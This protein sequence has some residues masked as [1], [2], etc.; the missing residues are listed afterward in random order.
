MVS[1]MQQNDQNTAVEIKSL[2]Q[3]S[4]DLIQHILLKNIV[5]FW[6]PQTLDME[7]GGFQ[8]NHDQQGRFKGPGKKMIVT[9]ARAVWF[10]SNL[11]NNGYTDNQYIKAAK[12]G[13]EFLREAMWDKEHGGFYWEVDTTGHT[14]TRPMKHLYGQGFGLYALSEYAMALNSKT[15]LE[16]A[17]K[18]FY[19]LERKAHDKT[20]GGYVESFNRDWSLPPGDENSYMSVPHKYKLMNTHLHLL[21]P[22][23]VYYQAS[24]NSLARE[25]LIELIQIQSNTVVR[26][27]MGACTDKY[28]ADWRPVHIPEFDVVS[29]GHDIENI[30]LLMLACKTAGISNSIFMDLYRTL[31]DY[32]YQYGYDRGNGGF[33]YTGTFFQEASNKTKVWW[34]QAEALVTSI[35]LYQATGEKLYLDCFLQTL[36]WVNQNM[37]DWEN[38]DW[39]AN[40]PDPHTPPEGKA[41]EWKCPYHNG[42]AMIR[43]SKIIQEILAK[44]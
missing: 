37:V 19:L 5:S 31:F 41:H 3:K 16:F 21:E 34:V 35:E 38:G 10:F 40:V 12:H 22:M 4:Q 25:R 11:I 39:F 15:A 23:T 1:D 29:Y 20:N 42:R 18:L 7:N 33:F 43:C 44:S 17:D 27:F 14:P 32:S 24:R 2:L 8:M 28:T 13:Y 26:K 6:Y 9:Q 30:W 36:E